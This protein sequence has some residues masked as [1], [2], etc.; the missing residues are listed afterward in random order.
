[1]IVIIGAFQAIFESLAVFVLLPTFDQASASIISTNMTLLVPL[2]L[3]GLVNPYFRSHGEKFFKDHE[4]CLICLW[5]FV[6]IV[7]AATVLVF[8]F[9]YLILINVNVSEEGVH[10]NNMPFLYA[11]TFILNICMSC[12]FWENVSGFLIETHRYRNLAFS[13]LSVIKILIYFFTLLASVG[14]TTHGRDVSGVGVLF[15]VGTNATIAML[16]K[17]ILLIS[18]SSFRDDCSARHPFY[19]ALVSLFASYLCFKACYQACRTYLQWQ[20]FSIPLLLNLVLLP[21]MVGFFLEPNAFYSKIDNC[22]IISND[23]DF[24]VDRNIQSQIMMGFC[25]GFTLL[26]VSMLTTY[27]WRSGARIKKLERY[28]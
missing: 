21:L 8:L 19:V 26:S 22:E 6:V 25:G 13:A 3:N 14:V 23:W 2:F 1:M 17:S 16:E 5:K 27:I 9:A 7:L 24:I 11:L 4:D 28:V 12:G 18:T 15:G 10:F 20:S